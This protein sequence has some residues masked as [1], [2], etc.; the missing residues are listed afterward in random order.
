MSAVGRVSDQM[1][2]PRQY[3]KR[4]APTLEPFGG[5]FIARG[6]QALNLE[7]DWEPGR[8]VVLE[9]PDME[10]AKAWHASESY[11]P[12]KELRQRASTGRMILVEGC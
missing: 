3:K 6:G 5:R 9:F 10:R 7:G 1:R 12:A 11:A 2:L 8:I 4:S